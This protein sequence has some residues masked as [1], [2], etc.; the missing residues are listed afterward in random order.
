MGKKGDLT[1]MRIL[2]AATYCFAKYGDRGTTFQRIADRSGVS[3]PYISKVFGSRDE[4]FPAVLE[5]FMSKAREKTES[6][7]DTKV[8]AS[9]R[10][11]A[12][13]KISYEIFWQSP[14]VA[15]I[16]NT[17]YYLSSFEKRYRDANSAIKETAVKRILSIL[18]I[19][20]L[21]GEFLV[22]NPHLTAKIIHNNLIGLLLSMTTEIPKYDGGSLIDELYRQTLKALWRKE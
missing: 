18:E 16:Y 15:R 13:F 10:L 8:L 5:S 11:H 6:Q 2:E 3:Q 9:E 7:L 14:E 20:I 19:G 17:L 1:R 21:S 22:P 4:I 12:Y